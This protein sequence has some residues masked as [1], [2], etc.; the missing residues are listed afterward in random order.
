M[1]GGN[2]VCVDVEVVYMPLDYNLLLGI[3][4]TYAMTVVILPV[5]W[6][7]CFPHEGRIVTI[8]QVASNLSDATTNPR[9]IVPWIQKSQKAIESI[10]C[11]MYPSLM[12]S[13]EFPAMNSYVWDTSAN[14]VT[15]FRM[16]Y[17]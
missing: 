2:Y 14:R 11:G 12:G 5:F 6:I 7:I 16:V 17:M 9:N 4:C 1:L 13:F 8:D 3:S 15:S 10:G